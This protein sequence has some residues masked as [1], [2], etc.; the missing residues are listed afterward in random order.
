MAMREKEE[1]DEPVQTT[2]AYLQLQ[3]EEAALKCKHILKQK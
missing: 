1:L 3:N 2:L